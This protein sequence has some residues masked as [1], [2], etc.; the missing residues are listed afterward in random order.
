VVVLVAVEDM[1]WT[2][3]G[4]RLGWSDKTARLHAAVTFE[5]LAPQI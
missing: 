4:R 2:A 3:L 5:R 1:P